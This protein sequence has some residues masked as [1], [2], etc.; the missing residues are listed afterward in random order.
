MGFELPKKSYRNVI[1]PRGELGGV[2]GDPLNTQRQIVICPIDLRPIDESKG[3]VRCACGNVV[4]DNGDCSV[5]FGNRLMCQRCLFQRVPLN[6]PGYVV[7][8]AKIFE[9]RKD[10]KVH[11]LTGMSKRELKTIEGQ[12]GEFGLTREGKPTPAGR[13]VWRSLSS[14]YCRRTY[15]VD[16]L[17]EM[18]IEVHV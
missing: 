14:V 15:V 12:L 13:M 16:I 18:G 5:E 7:L 4:H 6:E 11:E 9:P 10:A 1:A 3:F 17:N 2:T 8:T